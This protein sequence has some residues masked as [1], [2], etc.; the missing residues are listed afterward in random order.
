VE[1]PRAAHSLELKGTGGCRG[2]QHSNRGPARFEPREL[3][4]FR[5]AS[6][7][8]VLC[9]LFL[10]LL[11]WALR[12][13]AGLGKGGVRLLPLGFDDLTCVLRGSRSEL[14]LCPSEP[15]QRDGAEASGSQGAP[16]PRPAALGVSRRYR[17]F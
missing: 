10:Q 4:M 11:H 1:H 17:P 13:P 3:Q 14:F 6:W 12:A 2:F 5:G 15:S 7:L 16:A 8:Q 9:F